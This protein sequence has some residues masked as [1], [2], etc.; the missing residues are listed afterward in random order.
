MLQ[1]KSQCAWKVHMLSYYLKLALVNFKRAP[2]LYA[3]VLLTLSIGVGLLSANMALVGVM[4]GDPIP[5]KSSQLYHVSMNTWPNDHNTHG[6][7]LYII[8]Y[9]DGMMIDGSDIPKHSALFYETSV[10]ARDA[11]STSLSRQ[12]GTV[13]ATTPGFFALTEAPFAYGTGFIESSGNVVVI[14]SEFNQQIF[15][16]GN[17]VGKEIELAGELFTVVGVLQSWNLRPKFYHA[18]ENRAFDKTDDLYIPLESAIDQNW[19]A[20]ART[21]STDGWQHMFQTRERNV[22]YLQAWVELDSAQSK[23]DFQQFLDGYSQSLKDA[24]EHPLAIINELNNVNEWLTKQQV[25]DDK[26]LAFTIATALFLLV[27]VFNASSL[28]LSRF[29]AGKFEVGLR[30]AIG[31][32]KAQVLCQGLVESTLLGIITSFVALGLSSLFLILSV[33]M[34]PNL[35]N[36]A[37]LNN[38][39]LVLG[40][41]LSILTANFSALYAIYRAN[42]YSISAELK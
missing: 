30:R 10:Y 40:A 2:S 17:S 32:S 11:Q 12:S 19:R 34:L 37:V 31:A 23:Q 5:E 28:L 21:S 29:H 20:Q 15:G 36:I 26:I 27:C 39:T 38:E 42:R 3:L 14:G 41:L 1:W 16:G 24:G 18:T 6:E 35:A 33:K 7:P 8:R 9:R 4:A 13:R 22:Y 25:V